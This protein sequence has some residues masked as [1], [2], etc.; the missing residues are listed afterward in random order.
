MKKLIT[1]SKSDEQI[2]EQRISDELLVS[3]YKLVQG[4]LIGSSLVICITVA[5]MW[6]RVS[7]ELLITWGVLMT[8]A[9][10]F[11]DYNAKAF[12]QQLE[13]CKIERKWKTRFLLSPIITGLLWGAAILIIYNNGS[14]EHQIFII[15]IALSI[16]AMRVLVGNYYLPA[17]YVYVVPIFSSLTI[18]FASEGSFTYITLAIMIVLALNFLLSFSKVLNKT[19]RSELRL[20]HESHALADELQL[21]TEEAQQATMAKSRFLAAASHDLRQ[22]LHALSL[23]VDVL[24]ES[25]SA[26]ERAS[27]FPRLELSVDAL[28][29]LFDAL[30]DVSK[31]DAKVVK[32]EFTHFDLAEI[33][34]ILAKEF[35]EA[36]N[37]KNLKLKVH[38]KSSI[39]VSDRLLLERVLRNLISNAIRYTDKGGILLSARMRGDNVLLQVWDTGIG[40]PQESKEEVFVEFKQ[41]H[42]AHRDR[43]QGLGLGLSLVRRL[44]QLLNHPLKLDTRLGKGSVF[45]IWITTGNPAL[46]PSKNR[47]PVVHSWDLGGRRILVIDDEHEILHAMESLLSKWGCEAITADSL[48]DAINQLNNNGIVP[49]LVLSDLRL[50]DDKTGIEAI[51]GIQ[52]IFSDSIPGILITGDTDPEQIKKAK[53][54][55]Y[56]VLQKPVRPAHLRSVIQHH[57]TSTEE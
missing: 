1:S 42:N 8:A 55:G 57:L 6:A 16:S 31:L 32:P 35:N 45:S 28:R 15:T 40:I 54:S 18:C 46:S 41:L 29:K 13:K 22:P 36:A 38:A 48:D 23:F 19:M 11:S 10:V 26:E 7:H 20:R 50:R 30:L 12:F 2:I 37:K 33:L 34:N 43:T 51:D 3:A 56:E 27:I 14:V 25:K 17:Y 49:E 39:I 44:C 9:I 24:K 47:V 53:L 52:K 5:I 4:R 21:K